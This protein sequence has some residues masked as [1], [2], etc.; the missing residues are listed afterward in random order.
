VVRVAPVDIFGKGVIF[1]PPPAILQTW[2]YWKYLVL[3]TCA[4]MVVVALE[5][6]NKV[7][8]EQQSKLIE[9]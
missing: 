8:V 6:S 9:E 1:I 5:S 2:T 3:K 4:P 7:I